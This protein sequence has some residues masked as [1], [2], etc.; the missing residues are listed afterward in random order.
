MFYS[1]LNEPELVELRK[2][3]I[4]LE[5]MAG[6]LFDVE[7]LVQ[8]MTDWQGTDVSIARSLES[9]SPG[10]IT[11]K[12]SIHS[13]SKM[14]SKT[15]LSL[16]ME[17]AG[18]ISTV[19]KGGII[20]A[21]IAIVVNV[22]LWLK[23]QYDKV[24]KF[25]I[26]AKAEKLGERA[27]EAEDIS[28]DVVR[29]I[30]D[31]PSDKR[32]HILSAIAA[33][34]REKHANIKFTED[35][36]GNWLKT[37]YRDA[38]AARLGNLFSKVEISLIESGQTSDYVEFLGKADKIIKETI[39]FLKKA[40]EDLIGGMAH[41]EKIQYSK[42][43]YTLNVSPM[44]ESL[45][46]MGYTLKITKADDEIDTT[47]AFTAVT[48]DVKVDID[49]NITDEVVGKKIHDSIYRLELRES[50]YADFVDD[51]A[52]IAESLTKVSGN[53][54]GTVP[55]SVKEMRKE[56]SQSLGVIT[57]FNAVTMSLLTAV[58]VFYGEL[59]TASVQATGVLKS[60]RHIVNMNT[61]LTT[62]EKKV[63][64][65]IFSKIKA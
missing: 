34:I 43:Q 50:K 22:V 6:R 30:G 46:A 33:G 52:K 27:Q 8:S 1:D 4:A 16:A 26:S 21:I 61:T 45:K 54:Q 17:S 24:A 28:S 9:L 59:T 25:S 35:N 58:N 53:S 39:D 42:N 62:E 63:F 10:S 14:P 7:C 57:S 18:M 2:Q 44:M 15:N 11:D 51:V 32:T 23:G 48:N 65:A 40:S 64:S 13:F 19:I 47:A 20:A 55:D 3:S 5:S 29:A 36:H 49:R 60:V 38:M 56:I 41:P 12:V 37:L 31:L